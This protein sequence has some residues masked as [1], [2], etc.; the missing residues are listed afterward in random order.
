M[1]SSHSQPEPSRAA[2]RTRMVELQLQ[3]RGI[4]DPRVLE[5]MAAVPREHFVPAESRDLAYADGALSIGHGQTISQPYMVA[6]SCE[7]ASLAPEARVLEVGAGSG[8]QA[9]VLARLSA[10]VTAL[11]LV[12]PLADR[13]RTVLTA[14]GID[15]VRVRCGDGSLG[16]PPDAPYD[17]ILVAAGAPHVPEALLEQ[18][19]EGGRLVIP[20][21]GREL[22]W[23]TRITRRGQG[24]A[25][26]THEACV[27]VPLLGVD[28]LGSS[29]E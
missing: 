8:Y 18:L 6:R 23:L 26:E 10:Q 20:V 25:H 2:E 15:N 4:C 17:A 14:L 5:A 27:F 3:R 28:G 7:L 24:F 29:G 21:G 16:Y 22:Q 1:E 9:A 11:E 19:A 12:E 13:A